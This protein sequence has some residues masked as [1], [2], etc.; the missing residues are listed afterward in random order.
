MHH[1]DRTRRSRPTRYRKV[2]L[3]CSFQLF[4]EACRRVS[5]II[6]FQTKTSEIDA[7]KAEDQNARRWCHSPSRTHF[8]LSTPPK[9]ITAVC[10]Q[11]ELLEVPYSQSERAWCVLRDSNTAK[12]ARVTEKISSAGM[13]CDSPSL[14]LLMKALTIPA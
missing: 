10:R 9:S 5:L 14:M 11:N 13:S 3:Q 12:V 6:A 8:Y 4:P 2:P 1:K 7:G